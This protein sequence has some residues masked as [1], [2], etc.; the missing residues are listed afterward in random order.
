MV[1][2]LSIDPIPVLETD[3]LRLRPLE[4]A[5]APAVQ[6]LAGHPAIADTTLNIP[7]PYPDGLAEQW[8]AGRAEVAR[9]G[10]GVTWAIADRATAELYGAI[11]LAITWQHVHAELGYWLGVPYW[12]RGYTTEAA[13]AVIAYAFSALGLNRV[14]ARHLPRNP[15]SGRVMQKNGM[16]YEGVQRQHIRKGDRFEDLV[17]Y[18]VLREE[19]AAG[20]P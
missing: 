12:G 7:H 3:R 11:S 20:H 4:L 1:A 8:I 2:A 10:S 19:W 14:V 13:A 6:R 9:G 17:C 5:D 18:G 16:R 15:A